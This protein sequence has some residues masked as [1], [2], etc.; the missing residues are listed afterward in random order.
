MG[1]N[2]ESESRVVGRPSTPNNMTTQHPVII[3][4]AGLA[5]LSC[6]LHLTR[7]GRK[8]LV[9]E[10][11]D[12]V[13]G[14][15]RTDQVDGFLLDRGFQVLFTA[16]PEAQ[17]LLDYGALDLR[18]FFPGALVHRSGR[19]HL[20]A[21]PSRRPLSAFRSLFSSMGTLSDKMQVLT[22]RRLARTGRL[23]DLYGRPATTSLDALRSLELSEAMLNGFFRPL[24]GG[25]FL[26]R[27]LS[28][29]SRMLEFVIRMM[30]NGNISIP[31]SG[32]G[33]IPAHLAA[34]LPDGSI[35]TGTKV[36]EVA[37]GGITTETGE[38]IVAP[39]VVVATE[40]DV[41]ADLTGRFPTPGY[42]STS[43]LYFTAEAP[44]YHGPYLM[45]DGD[46]LGPVNN[47]CVLSEVSPAY[48]PTGQVLISA[49]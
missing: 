34:H 15:V 4:G 49:T 17:Q 48:A 22:L 36:V 41:A 25:I 19:T 16:Y 11:A 8:V 21:D 3:V 24:L 39:A 10:A 46:G 43:T 33:A 29:S 35:R 14:R 37:A 18:S 5:G 40:G 7:R 28:T 38:R 45:L 31:A 13:G 44:P 26:G 27:D 9:L 1:G 6:A 32:M 47:L 20:M 12:A 2:P 23:A 30:A 42:R